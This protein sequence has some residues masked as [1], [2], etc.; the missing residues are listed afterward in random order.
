MTT[1]Q[2]GLS[3]TVITGFL[4]SLAPIA[5][6]AQQPVTPVPQGAQSQLIVE[7][8]QNSFL[9]APDFKVTEV[10]R[11]FSKLAGL[12]GGWVNDKRLLIGAGGY[13]LTN[14]SNDLK[15]AYGGLVVGW[16]MRQD[17]R[18]GFGAKGLVGLG[19][20]TLGT[21]LDLASPLLDRDRQRG[22][23]MS[24]PATVSGRRV[25][26]IFHDQFFVAEPEVNVSLKL[27]KWL[28][29]SGGVG[30]RVIGSA[31]GLEDR[32]RGTTGNLAL[33]FGGGCRPAT[34][35]SHFFRRKLLEGFVV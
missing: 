30:Y 8:I 21:T 3:R 13:W 16:L 7:R 27:A 25:R 34:F 17:R 18:L 12:Y 22:L 19:E 14:R 11:N 35:F 1:H 26:V 2:I 5:A 10:D 6:F 33:Q 32:L 15:M 31:E 29:L 4:L 9:V 20:G 23:R 24:A 28:R